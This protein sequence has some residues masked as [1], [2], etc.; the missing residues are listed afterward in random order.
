MQLML[1]KGKLPGY[2]RVFSE[3]V[4]DRFLNVTTYT[5]YKNTRALG[6]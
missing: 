2:S 6:W 1:N 4:V 3:E 5:K